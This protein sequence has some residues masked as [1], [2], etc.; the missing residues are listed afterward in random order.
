M[1]DNSATMSR[2]EK[3]SAEI[4]Q[5]RR[6]QAALERIFKHFQN[7]YFTG[8]AFTAHFDELRL[9]STDRKE[10]IE[11][12][13]RGEKSDY[14]SQIL[15][16][17][18]ILARIHNNLF[19]GPKSLDMIN[20]LASVLHAASLALATLIEAHGRHF[21]RERYTEELPV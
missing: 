20:S 16:L 7:R 6:C 8:A 2:L 9:R 18:F 4:V 13:L 3:L 14:E 5:R 19:R 12:A 1:C 10:F 11:A 21:K 17:L 15:A